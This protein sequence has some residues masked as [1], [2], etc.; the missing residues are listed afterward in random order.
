MPHRR[1]YTAELPDSGRNGR[2]RLENDKA[3]PPSSCA[4]STQ[5][6]FDSLEP[7]QAAASPSVPF[8]VAWFPRRGSPDADLMYLIWL[9]LIPC[10]IWLAF[11]YFQDWYQREPIWLIFVTFILGA[12]SALVALVLNSGGAAVLLAVFGK[13]TTYKVLELWLV[14]GP[15]EELVKMSAVLVFAYRRK[16]FDE[17]SDGVIYAA[18][19]ALGFAALENVLYLANRGEQIILLR[20]TFANPGHAL[21]AAIWGL[22]LSKAKAAPNLASTRAGII[23]LGW[24]IA[25]VVHAVYDTLCLIGGN[26]LLMTLAMLVVL[27]IGMFVY[28]E[29]RLIRQVLKS[30]H[31]KATMF[32]RAIVRCPACGMP[33]PS[34]SPCWKCHT[35]IGVFDGSESKFCLRCGVPQQPGATQCFNCGVNLL[36]LRGTPALESR[37]HFVRAATE[38]APR[39]EIAYVISKPTA[40]VGK[41]LE[42]DFVVDDESASKHHARLTWH[43][44]GAHVLYD[45]GAT[46]GVYVNGQ[47]ILQAF[48]QDGYEVRFGQ[49]R[50]VYRMTGWRP[51]TQLPPPVLWQPGAQPLVPATQP[52]PGFAPQSAPPGYPAPQSAPPGYPAPQ[53]APPGYPA[54]QP[55]PPGYPAPQSAPPG[56]P[57][58]QPAPP[59]YPAPQSAPPGYPAPQ[60][61][62]PAPF[63]YPSQPPAAPSGSPGSPGSPP[64]DPRFRR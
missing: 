17:P 61:A 14:V 43:P 22:A 48:L 45:L 47:R 1:L 35:P 51:P 31:R 49:A 37:P 20:G 40:N 53:S 3:R 54:P 50:Y 11:F 28:V 9:S 16:E 39:G 12:A 46:N 57:A 30:P 7:L 4:C 62:P 42:N 21:Y 15:I 18:A 44:V 41:T 60:P 29:I 2:Y 8:P 23:A 27:M 6:S 63:G 32:M 10:L 26:S 36:E 52:P 24:L 64:G 55:A 58:P 13:T 19:A 59:G 25:A 38:A 33:T 56:Y 5:G 34:G